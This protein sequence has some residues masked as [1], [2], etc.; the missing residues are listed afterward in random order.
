M[1]TD[2][3]IKNL[4]VIEQLQVRFGPGFNVLTGETGAGK[5]I[6]I[7]AMGLLLGQRM[8]NDLVRTGEET[9]NVEAVFSL[10]DQP[11]VRR[12]LQ[13]MDFDDDD[14]LVIRRSLSRQGKN[15]VYVNGALATLTQLQQLVTPMLAIFGQHDQQQ[16]QR[17]ENHLRLLDGFGQ[18]QDLLLEYQQCYRQWRQ[19]RHQ[20][21]ALQQAER[22]RTARIDLLSF[23][24]EEIRSAALQPGEDESLATER[25]RLQYAER[26]YAGCQQGYERL[27][28]DEGAVCEQ[29]G[30]L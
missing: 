17:A 20:L 16:L 10:T 8:R 3:S 19:Q 1:L 13:E 18:C 22:D 7:D 12:L 23:Q 28:A 27:Y 26:L 2:L 30:A 25:L 24:L 4:A 14:E 21:E 9:A 11:E 29:L 5:S 15:R 6:I